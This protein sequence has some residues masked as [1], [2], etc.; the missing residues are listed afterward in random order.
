MAQRQVDAP[1]RDTTHT[2]PNRR[3]VVVSAAVGIVAG[4]AV[5]AAVLFL[6]PLIVGGILLVVAGLY[7]VRRQFFNWTTMLFVLTGVILFVPIRRFALPIPVGFALEPYRV[8]IAGLLVALLIWGVRTGGRGFQPVVWGWPIAIF[9]WC[10]FASLMI[11]AVTL[12]QSG[13]ITAGFANIIQLAFLLSVVVL[14]RQMM[15][16]EKVTMILLNVIVFAGAFI[17]FFAF[18]ERVTRQNIFL[19][20]HNF[21]PLTLLRDDAESLRAGGARAY[22]S[23]QHPI[24]LAV[25][26]CMIIPLAIYLMKFSP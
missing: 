13:L 1:P 22:A 18:V 7:V 8:L 24:A 4:A 11:N 2:G 20:L 19:M 17:G 23:S 25:L 6:D 3:G 9:L 26:F 12:T 5:I 15:S 10:A 16:T 21:L 14:A